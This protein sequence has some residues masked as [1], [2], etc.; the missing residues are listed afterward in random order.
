MPFT[1]EAPVL[2]G[3]GD[4]LSLLFSNSSKSLDHGSKRGIVHDL[5]EDNC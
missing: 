2:P 3:L 5:F 4:M 1:S